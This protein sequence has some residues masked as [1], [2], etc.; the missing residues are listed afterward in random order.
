MQCLSNKSINKCVLGILSS[1]LAASKTS[2]EIFE[3]LRISVE[4]F[5]FWVQHSTSWRRYW[6]CACVESVLRP[7][8]KRC[9]AENR[10][11][12]ITKRCPLN[13][14]QHRLRVCVRVLTY[15]TESMFYTLLLLA[16]SLTHLSG[17]IISPIL[18]KLAWRLPARNTVE[19]SEAFRM[20]HGDYKAKY[21]NLRF[22]FILILTL[23]TTLKLRLS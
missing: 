11:H 18:F 17:H 6:Y 16:R 21:V 9:R 15:L 8:V 10:T 2:R 5:D 19:M 23:P 7:R 12:F 13:I 3:Y 4:T 14:L 20:R 22:A 1:L